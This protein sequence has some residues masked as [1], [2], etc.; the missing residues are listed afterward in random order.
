MPEAI[1]T[2][3][4]DYKKTLADLDRLKRDN[5]P[6]ALAQS[7]SEVARMGKIAVQ[8]ITREKFKLHG[9]FIPRGIHS[10]PAQKNDLLLYG[11][12]Q[13]EVY[14]APIISDFMPI[15]EKGGELLPTGKA[16]RGG[17]KGKVLAIPGKGLKSLAFETSQGMVKTKYLPKTLLNKK[18][19]FILPARNGKAAVIVHRVVER[20]EG[21][22]VSKLEVMYVLVKKADYKPAWNFVATVEKVVAKTF[23]RVFTEEME[24]AL[25]KL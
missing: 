3:F 4:S 7:L 18:G 24:K 17:G 13:S 6:Y 12:I 5:F 1:I 14:T 22:K 2:V 19:Y 23:D 10:K 25:N 20:T 16:R 8:G 9:E 11:S 21:I 15:H